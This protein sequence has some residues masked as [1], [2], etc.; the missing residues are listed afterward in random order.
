LN[1]KHEERKDFIT[2]SLLK[3]YTAEEVSVEKFETFNTKDAVVWIDPLDGTSDFV[4]KNLPAVTVLIG[5]S[6]NGNSRLGVVHNP[7]KKDDEKNSITYYATAE[8][9]AYS[10]DYHNSMTIEET[11]KRTPTYLE[12]FDHFEEPA[13]NKEI[14]VAASLQHSS[15]QMVE[16]LNLIAPVEIC[17]IGG[18]GN[19]CNNLAIGN[20][21]C[22]I[23]PSPGLKFWDLCAPESIIKAMGG[24]STDLA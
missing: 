9:G 16:I 15:P 14:K 3:T 12:P 1:S 11:L 19:K 24:Y 8:H 10:L 23:H 2:N 21:D 4:K 20:V 22:Y 13:A 18:A 6:I 5:L 17:K 7:F